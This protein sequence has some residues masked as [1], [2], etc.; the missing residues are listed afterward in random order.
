MDNN[1]YST[2][3]I[4]KTKTKKKNKI[5]IFI[6]R[7]LKISSVFLCVLLIIGGYK[8]IA[9]GINISSFGFSLLGIFTILLAIP[10]SICL[11]CW[12]FYLTPNDYDNEE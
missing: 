2:D 9:L 1:N 11:W 5:K 4:I 7:I 6:G 10:I 3:I 12:G 8:E